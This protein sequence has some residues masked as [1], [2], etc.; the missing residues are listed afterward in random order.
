MTK[1]SVAVMKLADLVIATDGAPLSKHDGCWEYAIDERWWVAWNGHGEHRKNSR[2]VDVPPYTCAV[3]YNGWPAGLVNPY[4][5]VIA[6][7]DAANEDTFIAAIESALRAAQC[8]HEHATGL[9]NADGNGET[10]CPECGHVQKIG[11]GLPDNSGA[12]T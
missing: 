5:G 10:T 11:R 7:G 8:K 12:G 4:G 1:V 9:M 2:G 3:H 6:A